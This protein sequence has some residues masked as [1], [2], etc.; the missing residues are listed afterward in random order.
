M[1]TS[2]RLEEQH[3][4]YQSTDPKKT[5]LNPRQAKWYMDMIKYIYRSKTGPMEEHC[6][7]IKTEKKESAKHRKN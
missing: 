7:I 1:A 4:M 6:S 3:K 5:K 2:I